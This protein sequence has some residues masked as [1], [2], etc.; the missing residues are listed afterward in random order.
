MPEQEDE[1]SE[2]LARRTIFISLFIVD[3]LVAKLCGR[4]TC[5]LRSVCVLRASFLRAFGDDLDILNKRCCLS[6]RTMLRSSSSKGKKWSM[7]E[8]P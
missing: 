8:M 3:E 2:A 7:V 1:A 5:V 4:R 6:T